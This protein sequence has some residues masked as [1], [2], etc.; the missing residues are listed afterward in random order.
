MKEGSEIR[1]REGGDKLL[2]RHEAGAMLVVWVVPVH[3]VLHLSLSELLPDHKT[4]I[5]H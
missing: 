2:R 4:H 1:R 3:F 5:F